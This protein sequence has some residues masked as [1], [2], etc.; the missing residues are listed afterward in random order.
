M[1]TFTE[2]NYLEFLVELRVKSNK[3][4]AK[5]NEQQVKTNKQRAKTNEQR[6]KVSPRSHEQLKF[7][8]NYTEC[9]FCTVYVNYSSIGT[10]AKH[11]WEHLRKWVHQGSLKLF[12]LW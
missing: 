2:K 7:L 12:R 10:L 3:Q 1:F 9:W 5:S 6:A 11:L 4:R 8:S